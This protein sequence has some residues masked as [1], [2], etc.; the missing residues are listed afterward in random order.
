ME[1]FKQK[2]LKKSYPDRIKR[3]GMGVGCSAEDQPEIFV[4]VVFHAGIG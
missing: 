3:Q 1:K 2:S 4:V